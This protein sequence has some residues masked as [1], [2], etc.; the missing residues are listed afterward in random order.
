MHD[1]IVLSEGGTAVCAHVV[2]QFTSTSLQS[3]SVV[4]RIVSA[5]ALNLLHTPHIDFPLSLLALSISVYG[6]DKRVNPH[7]PSPTLRCH[8]SAPTPS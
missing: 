2:P 4:E 7:D 6:V 8:Y 3:A 5:C 1:V